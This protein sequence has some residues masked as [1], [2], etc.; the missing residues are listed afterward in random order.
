MLLP[1]PEVQTL[2]FILGWGCNPGRG[3]VE[4]KK[5]GKE[6]QRQEDRKREE[7]KKPEKIGETERGVDISKCPIG[8]HEIAWGSWL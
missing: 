3:K 6:R 5:E 2:A 4:A 1:Y 7:A 8:V